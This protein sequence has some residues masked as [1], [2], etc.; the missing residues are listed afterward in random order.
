MR[1]RAELEMEEVTEEDV[2]LF[3]NEENVSSTDTTE[4]RILSIDQMLHEAGGFGSWHLYSFILSVLNG[5]V[6]SMLI[7]TM[8]FLE[9]MPSMIC[10]N[11][12]GAEFHCTT[13]DICKDGIRDYSIPLRLDYDDEN[14][15][16]NWIGQMDL[17]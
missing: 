3:K 5:S 6:S 1:K 14:T 10:T 16:D 9:K 17:F 4:R 8:A 15:I 2:N 13:S 7:Y 12:S 11:A